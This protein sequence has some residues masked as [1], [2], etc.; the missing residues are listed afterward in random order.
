M[1]VCQTQLFQGERD[2]I[3]S[4]KAFGLLTAMLLLAACS[5]P[6]GA[7]LQSEVLDEARSDNPSFQVVAVTRANMPTVSRWPAT[8]GNGD[9][10]WLDATGG[11][12]SSMIRSGDRVNVVIWDSQENSLLTAPTEKATSLNN[13][14]VAPN[15]SIFLPYINDVFVSGMTPATARERIQAQL[16]PIVPSAQVQLSMTQGIGNSVDLV[17]GVQK[18]GS[19]PLPSRNY[20]VLSLLAAGGGISPSLKRPK[21]RLM[22]G[23]ATYQ[24]PAHLL[25]ASAAKNTTLRPRDTVIVEEDDRVF[26]ALGAS[27]TE[28]LISF[29]KEE[30]TALEAISLMGGLSDS[31][32]DPKGVLVLREYS[33]L[34]VRL[35][36]SGPDRA[37]VIFTFDLTTADGLFAARQFQINPQD[38]VLATESPVTK[39]QTIFGLIGSGFGLARQASTVTN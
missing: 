3:K 26:T 6:R 19:Y 8:G 38:T 12:S 39:A 2:L 10:H 37:Q 32:A 34:D 28:D 13:I 5:L 15:G 31:R 29:P 36:D 17:A 30:V 25:Y 33:P 24:I 4:H 1:D 20:S 18:P 11:P 7:A 22:R 35:D 21:V 27:G 23:G 14:E 9:Y 16:E